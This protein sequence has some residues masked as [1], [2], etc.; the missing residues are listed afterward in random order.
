MFVVWCGEG[1]DVHEFLLFGA[2]ASPPI[3]KINSRTIHYKAGGLELMCRLNRVLCRKSLFPRPLGSFF[4][5]N[6]MS[7]P[8][9]E[10]QMTKGRVF[11]LAP[12]LLSKS[13]LI[14]NFLDSR[15]SLLIPPS[16]PFCKARGL[17]RM[18]SPLGKT[19]LPC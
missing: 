10:L 1:E 18:G 7:S 14:H 15:M 13:L 12:E 16:L 4:P 17:E 6:T 2:S 11:R 3:S 5:K 9:E 8:R 19:G